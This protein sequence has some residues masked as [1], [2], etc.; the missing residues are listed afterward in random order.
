MTLSAIEVFMGRKNRIRK[1][2]LEAR[3]TIPV[4]GDAF[5]SVIG[6]LTNHPQTC[7]LKHQWILISRGSLGLLGSSPALKASLGHIFLH[8]CM[9]NFFLLFARR[10]FYFAAGCFYVSV[11]ILELCS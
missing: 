9:L 10:A 2:S 7:G 8:F 4:R 1:T 11:N 5:F 3:I 6:R